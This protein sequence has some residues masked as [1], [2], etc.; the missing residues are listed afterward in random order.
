MLTPT[1]EII[2]QSPI[3]NSTESMLSLNNP[4]LN[5]F[6]TINKIHTSPVINITSRTQNYNSYGLKEYIN[7]LTFAIPIKNTRTNI[8][9]AALTN[10]IN[11]GNYSYNSINVNYSYRIPVNKSQNKNIYFG[12]GLGAKN[13][14]FNTDRFTYE[15]QIN[16]A[17]QIL[18]NSKDQN[19]IQ[20]ISKFDALLGFALMS[21]KNIISFSYQNIPKNDFYANSNFENKTRLLLFISRKIQYSNA[22]IIQPGFFIE[23]SNYRKQILS[24]LEFHQ[25]KLK[26]GI[27]Y[28]TVLH[29]SKKPQSSLIFS[30]GHEFERFKIQYSIEKFNK[31]DIIG[32]EVTFNIKLNQV[33]LMNPIK[34]INFQELN[35][36]LF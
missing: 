7:T 21:P 32:N 28:R 34:K 35:N 11:I 22:F 16:S 1:I 5:N 13:M 10:Y 20:N 15:D 31:F 27:N 3:W 23:N 24:S 25:K 19:G 36:Y 9:G 33:K 17:G 29:N 30:L 12:F 6:Y 4:S 18:T 2:A 8:G 14:S 26:L